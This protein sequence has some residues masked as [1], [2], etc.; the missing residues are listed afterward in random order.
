MDQKRFDEWLVQKKADYKADLAD[1]MLRQPP[2]VA[3]Q[4]YWLIGNSV[5]V[6]VVRL[7]AVQTSYA[8]MRYQA[9]DEGCLK[10]NQCPEYMLVMRDAD[11][12]KFLRQNAEVRALVGKFVG[13]V[14]SSAGT[15]APIFEPVEL[16]PGK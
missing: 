11:A 1:G 15:P 10:N 9:S 5:P 3:D 6:G 4:R 2:L 14:T 13:V 12:G 8:R 16:Y 7:G